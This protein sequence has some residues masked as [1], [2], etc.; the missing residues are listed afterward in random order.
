[1][2]SESGESSYRVALGYPAYPGA[3]DFRSLMAATVHVSEQHTVKFIPC[4]GSETC[5]GFNFTWVNALAMAEKCEITHFAMLH[6]DIAPQQHWLDAL[7]AECDRLDAHVVSAVSPIKSA[8]GLTS[9][10]IDIDGKWRQRRLVMQ[11]IMRLPETFDIYDTIR[12][13]VNPD[14]KPLLLNT[15][16]WVADLRKSEWFE[17]DADGYS[18]FYFTFNHAIRKDPATGQWTTMA[19]SEDWWFSRRMAERN[20]TYY[21]TR[22]VALE[23]FGIHGFR[24]DVAWG[25]AAADPAHVLSEEAVAA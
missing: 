9:T 13:G 25:T 24:N 7:V 1:M 14:H 6:A 11:E 17:L 18:P 21:A 3:T 10:A 22:K 8:E 12:L 20:M 2:L 23:H 4:I 19:E 16:C 5:R 15:G